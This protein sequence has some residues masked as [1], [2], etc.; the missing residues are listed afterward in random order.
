M[1]ALCRDCKFYL[2]VDVFQGICKITKDSILPD[3]ERCDERFEKNMKFKF[4]KKFTMAEN[5]ADIGLC[6]GKTESYPDM[7]ATTC[8]WFQWQE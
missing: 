2:P 8:E 7:T 1:E 4:C 6:M 5:R 3:A